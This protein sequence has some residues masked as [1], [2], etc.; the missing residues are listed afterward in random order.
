MGKVVLDGSEDWKAGYQNTNTSQFVV[1]SSNGK[2]DAIV[3]NDKFPFIISA[4]YDLDIEMYHMNITSQHVIGI[5]KSKLSTTDVN[6]F[7]QWLS[8]NPTTVVYELAEPWYEPIGAY[9]KVV[10][11]GSEEWDYNGDR[12]TAISFWTP[13]KGTISGKIHSNK[14]ATN[15][16][17]GNDVE[18][19]RLSTEGN[20]AINIFKSRLSTQKFRWYQTM[21]TTKSYNSNL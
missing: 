9:G 6:G 18:L 7:K 10:L 2:G 3:Y 13:I 8:E 11:D 20:I 16:S 1:P 4:S 5:S 17:D 15:V 19:V 12:G 14:F 21:V